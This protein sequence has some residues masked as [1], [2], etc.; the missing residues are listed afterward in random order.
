MTLP[1]KIRL[2]HTALDS[3]LSCERKFQLDRLLIGAEKREET[4]HTVFGKSFGEGVAS[5]LLTASQDAALFAAYKA[6]WPV[7]ETEK[8]SELLAI[9]L[10]S[11][12]FP[13]LDNLM[14]EWEVA[15][16]QDKPAVELSFRLDI[17]ERFYYVGYVDIVLRNKFSGKYAIMENKTTGLG[18]HDLSALYQNSGQALGYSIVLD[19]IVGSEQSDYE[20]LYFVGQLGKNP[21]EPKIHTLPYPKTIND[22]LNWFISVGIDVERMQRMLSLN[23]FPLRGKSCLNFMRPCPHLGTCQLH[24]LDEYKEDIPDTI[25]YQFTYNLDDV[26]EDHLRRLECQ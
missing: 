10:L 20:V 13:H 14:M 26:I 17:D 9:Q 23:V 4:E 12:S 5:Y 6:Y 2:S 21:W 16:F 1:A 22:R 24:S 7:L 15:T 11:A 8:K 25:Q 3:F 19:Q 18:L